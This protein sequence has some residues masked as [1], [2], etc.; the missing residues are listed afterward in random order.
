MFHY[1]NSN[2]FSGIY[3]NLDWI[4]IKSR[5]IE[6]AR[7]DSNISHPP[8]S[9]YDFADNGGFD[10][11]WKRGDIKLKWDNPKKFDD[12]KYDTNW[13]HPIF[14]KENNPV[15]LGK[16]N[17]RMTYPGQRSKPVRVG[18]NRNIQW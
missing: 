17:G 16:D 14:V 4:T 12:G 1:T 11:M 15:K 2:L 10:P 13:D 5:T 6:T 7:A 18:G 9:V 3:A 8:F